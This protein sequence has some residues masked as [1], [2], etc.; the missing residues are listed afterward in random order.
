MAQACL[1]RRP[2]C[3]EEEGFVVVGVVA[4]VGSN[5][6]VLGSGIRFSNSGKVGKRFVGWSTIVK[7]GQP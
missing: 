7:Y 5:G 3:L 6:V 1:V 4:I 2:F